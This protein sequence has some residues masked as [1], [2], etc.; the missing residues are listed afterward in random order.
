MHT[1]PTPSGGQA[2]ITRE[3]DPA[4]LLEQVLARTEKNK[5][6]LLVDGALQARID[7]LEELLPP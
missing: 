4:Q 1:Q 3:L 6:V 2:V 7:K 5:R